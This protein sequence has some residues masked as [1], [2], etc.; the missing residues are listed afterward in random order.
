MGIK[1]LNKYLKTHCSTDAIHSIHLEK[2]RGRVIVIDAFIYM[3]KFLSDGDLEKQTQVFIET[4]KTYEISPI[5]IFDG[6]PPPEKRALLA[7][8]NKKKCD[9]ERQYNRLITLPVPAEKRLL[10]DSQLQSLKR[11]FIRV[12]PSHIQIVKKVL[13]TH[14]IR[15]V[16]ASGEADRTCVQ[17]VRSNKAWGCL[18]DDTDM[19]VHG[20]THVLRSF[21]PETHTVDLYVLPVILRE[22]KLTMMQFRDILVLS[23]TDYNT[24]SQ[25]SLFETMRLFQIYRRSSGRSKGFY[26]WLRFH[27]NYIKD[28][29]K[30]L[31][32]YSMFM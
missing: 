16:H 18:S 17:L 1:Q 28:Y 5:F 19:F 20:C 29:E 12:D 27:T 22:L 25:G 2:L 11:Q 24:E 8:R 15:Y 3:Y 13:D 23:G 30:L 6:K 10:V 7:I 9:A 21:S 4:L 26:D 31:D 32:T 14:D